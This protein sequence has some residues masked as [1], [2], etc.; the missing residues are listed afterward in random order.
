MKKIIITIILSLNLFSLTNEAKAT[1]SINTL[2]A[3]LHCAHPRLGESSPARVLPPQLRLDICKL[4]AVSLKITNTALENFDLLLQR[5]KGCFVVSLDLARINITDEQLEAILGQIGGTLRKLKLFYCFSL[6]NLSSIANCTGLQVLDLART[7]ITDDKL[8]TILGQINGSLIKLRLDDCLRLIDFSSILN[9]SMLQKLDLAFTDITDNELNAIL[10]AI[11]GR[12]RR[13]RLDNCRKLTDFSFIANCTGLQVL[14]LS[15]T[16]ITD[17]GLNAIL[18]AI[19]RNLGV[20]KIGYC[21][22]LTE[23][24]ESINSKY[25]NIQVVSFLN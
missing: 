13:L 12:L 9:C 1:R 21:E 2:E 3:F 19:G 25:P 20:L 22:N 7:D 14:E 11:G 24:K 17:D 4:V 6:T 10:R 15:G 18:R 8:A 16:G 23:A 5:L